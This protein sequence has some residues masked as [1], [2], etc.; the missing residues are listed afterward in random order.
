MKEWKNRIN[1][2]RNRASKIRIKN[3]FKLRDQ[4]KLETSMNSEQSQADQ[5]RRTLKSLRD[6]YFS[7]LRKERK[8]APAH[9]H[10]L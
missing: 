3:P 9:S 4:N 8:T 6:I 7:E 10:N 1:L 5:P 2:G